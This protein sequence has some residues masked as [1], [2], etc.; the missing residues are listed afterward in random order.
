METLRSVVVTIAGLGIAA[1]MIVV[2]ATVGLAVIGFALVATVIG[3]IAV[4]LGY[5]PKVQKRHGSRV[6][7]DG[8]GTII[9]M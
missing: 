4:K 7:N 3:L 6:W 9:D 8:H 2:M 1:L 5:R